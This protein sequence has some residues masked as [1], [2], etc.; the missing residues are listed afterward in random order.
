MQVSEKIRVPASASIGD[1][2]F[3]RCPAAENGLT[4]VNGI[5][6]DIDYDA[7]QRFLGNADTKVTKVQLPENILEL[8]NQSLEWIGAIIDEVTI[9][10]SVKYIHKDAFNVLGVRQFFLLNH[11]SGK[12]IFRTAKFKS[13]YSA[14]THLNESESFLKMCESRHISISIFFHLINDYIYKIF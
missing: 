6:F 1:C 9:T 12:T 3:E 13:S 5:L 10:D 2:A 11:I 14:H 8:S 4:V 7:H